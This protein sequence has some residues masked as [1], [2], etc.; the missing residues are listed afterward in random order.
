MN[1]IRPSEVD[2]LLADY[3]KAKNNLKWN[4]EITF[5]KLIIDMVESDLEF[6]KNYEY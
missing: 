4:P 1:L 3:T 2:T 5:D 6:T